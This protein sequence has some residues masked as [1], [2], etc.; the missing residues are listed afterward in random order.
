MWRLIYTALEKW[1]DANLICL[2]PDGNAVLAMDYREVNREM[3]EMGSHGLPIPEE[4]GPDATNVQIFRYYQ[5]QHPFGVDSA[6]AGAV[7]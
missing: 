2:D 4:L 1:V 3:E 5:A 6:P 7:E